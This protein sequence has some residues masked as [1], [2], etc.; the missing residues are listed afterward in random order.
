MKRG[1]GW[2][3]AALM[4]AGCHKADDGLF[5]SNRP[6]ALETLLAM[7]PQGDFEPGRDFANDYLVLIY[8]T[9]LTCETCK[10]RELKVLAEMA[11]R[12]RD[13]V[14]FA[15]VTNGGESDDY[16]RL[17]K[18]GLVNFPILRETIAGELGLAG[19]TFLIGFVDKQ[20]GTMVLEYHPVSDPVKAHLIQEF[21]SRFLH[22][23]E[24]RG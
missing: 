9:Q 8:V 16:R 14:D 10:L 5:A 24:S 11:T 4:F 3:L 17:R 21:E 13:R 19:A 22:Y 7:T 23:I 20:S 2:L 1:T 6:I 18:I 12:Y 15:L